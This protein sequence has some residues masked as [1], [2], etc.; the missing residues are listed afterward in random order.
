MDQYLEK[1]KEHY[2]QGYN[3]E[4]VD[5]C[6]FRVYGSILRDDFGIDGSKGERVLDFGCGQGTHVNYFRSKGFDAYGVDISDHDLGMAAKRYP[7]LASKFQK[8]DPK[9]KATDRFFDKD[10]DIVVGIQSYYFLSPTDMQTRLRSI[11]NQMKPGAIFYATMMGRDSFYWENAKPVGDDLYVVNVKYKR[12]EIKNLYMTFVSDEDDLKRKFKMFKPAHIGF[13]NARFRSD[14]GCYF[15]Y[16]FIGHKPK[17][18]P[19]TI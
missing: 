13:Y 19:A 18:G 10:F 6:V 3:A 14:E 12:I 8:I 9:P 5:H 1:N 7:A 17:D 11:Y 4:C 15:H 2:E 16:T